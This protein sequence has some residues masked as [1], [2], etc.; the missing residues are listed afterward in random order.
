M[1]GGDSVVLPRDEVRLAAVERYP[2]TVGFRPEDGRP[3]C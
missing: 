3:K 2:A 1:E